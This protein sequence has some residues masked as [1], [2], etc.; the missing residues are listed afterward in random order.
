MPYRGV[1]KSLPQ[2]ARELNVDAVIE[3]TVARSNGQVRITAQLIQ[4]QT[5]RHL[6]SQSY[7]RDLKDV[8]GLQYEI[9][10]AIAKSA[11]SLLR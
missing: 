9:A 4:A 7:Q 11:P 2:V 5:D 1:H 6:W 8:L 3:G 10:N